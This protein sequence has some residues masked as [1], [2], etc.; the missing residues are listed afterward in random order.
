MPENGWSCVRCA[1]LCCPVGGESEG[2]CCS[3]GRRGTIKT[4][5]VYQFDMQ[6]SLGLP[7]QVRFRSFPPCG[8]E[9]GR[10]GTGIA[11][12]SVWHVHRAERQDAARRVDMLVLSRRR[13]STIRIGANVEITVLGIQKGRVRLGIHAPDDI[14]VQRRELLPPAGGSLPMQ[15]PR[16]ATV[17]GGEAT[18]VISGRSWASRRRA[19]TAEIPP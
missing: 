4:T 13:D 1:G 6:S 3:F 15:L 16:C 11:G 2:S 14:L 18:T 9:K 7:S 5:D 12:V 10:N 8:A 17:D 19:L